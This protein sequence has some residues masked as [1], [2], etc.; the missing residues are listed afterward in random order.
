M[1]NMMNRRSFIK[2]LAATLAAAA[3]AS[4]LSLA[5]KEKERQRFERLIRAGLITNETFYL[6][7]PIVITGDNLR[8]EKCKFVITLNASISVFCVTFTPVVLL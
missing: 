2:S 1:V 6:T 3:V 5:A 4:P 8:I 7:E